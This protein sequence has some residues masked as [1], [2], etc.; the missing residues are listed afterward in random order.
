MSILA[1]FHDDL[2]ANAAAIGI[3][4]AFD[5]SRPWR[6]K[7]TSAGPAIF[8]RQPGPSQPIDPSHAAGAR[9]RQVEDALNVLVAQEADVESGDL[10]TRVVQGRSRY[11]FPRACARIGAGLSLGAAELEFVRTR[12][13]TLKAE[14]R[15][16][17]FS[18]STA[19]S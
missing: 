17:V 19:R 14:P 11:A 7:R 9:G 16:H 13:L 15:Q 5:R 18:L 3:S 6:L 8:S 12:N 4:A 2:F 10:V 1:A